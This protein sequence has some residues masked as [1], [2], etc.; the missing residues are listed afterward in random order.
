MVVLCGLKIK[1]DTE[2]KSAPDYNITISVMLI[3]F[4]DGR[5]QMVALNYQRQ[6]RNNYSHGIKAIVAIRGLHL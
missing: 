2:W 6:V 3:G 4:G 5:G 1:G